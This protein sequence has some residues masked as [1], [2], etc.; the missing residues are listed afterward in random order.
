MPRTSPTPQVAAA[1]TEQRRRFG[2]RDSGGA[3]VSPLQAA[4]IMPA[5]HVHAIAARM[6][7]QLG[8]PYYPIG[9]W[10]GGAHSVV[11]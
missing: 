4:S 2:F 8:M 10:A 3:Q 5:L 9:G 1:A 7:A 6:G 11:G